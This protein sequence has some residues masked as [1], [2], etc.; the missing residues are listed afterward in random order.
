MRKFREVRA[1][2]TRGVSEVVELNPQL[3]FALDLFASAVV[4][5]LFGKGPDP[6]ASPHR[7]GRRLNAAFLRGDYHRSLHVFSGHG[8]NVWFIVDVISASEADALNAYSVG[9]VVPEFAPTRL[10]D[11]AGDEVALITLLLPSEY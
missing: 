1:V 5:W 2:M 7:D 11:Y 10:G 6:C 8:V 9:P 4:R 3:A